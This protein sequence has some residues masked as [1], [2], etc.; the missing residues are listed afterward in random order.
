MTTFPQYV[1]GGWSITT[2]LMQAFEGDLLAKEGAEGVYTMAL[3]PALSRELTDRLKVTDDAPVAIALKIDDG[4][5]ERGRNPV[6]LRTLELLGIDLA[7]RPALDTW[8]EW[9]VRNVAGHVVGEVRAD[10]EL[11]IL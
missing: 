9:P 2:P 11:E 6:I 3:S 7:G 5:M 4:S 8:R 1:A 10:F